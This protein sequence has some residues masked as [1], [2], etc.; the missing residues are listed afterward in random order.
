MKFAV[1]REVL[2]QPLQ[3][4]MGVVEKRQTMAVLNN[5]LFE[6]TS[7][8]LTLTG[9]DSEV[10][11]RSKVPLNLA[12]P[13]ELTVPARKLFD[14]VRSLG[15]GTEL[16]FSKQA[17]RLVMKAGRS[18]FTLATLAAVEFPSTD[19]GEVIFTLSIAQKALKEVLERVAFAMAVSDVRYYLNGMLFEVRGSGLRCVATDGHRLAIADTQS[20]LGGLSVERQIILP[21]KGVLELQKLLEGVDEPVSLAFSRNHVR[22]QVG[23]SQFTSKLIEGKFPDYEAVIPIGA[24]K[25][26]VVEREALRTALQRAAILANEK[27][28]GVRLE[29]VAKTLRVSAQNPEQEEAYEELNAET[30]VSGI[31]VGF[32]VN[33]LLDAISA[34]DGESLTLALRD[35][36]SSG[37]LTGGAGGRIRHVVM[38]LRL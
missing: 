31:S 34:L 35:S 29:L 12:E 9:S 32:N 28:R 4:V 17:E 1:L 14:L 19:V 27:Y 7:D 8:G 15:D 13:G 10:E 26:A 33:Y 24:E 25:K 37:L 5:L 21:R 11:L 38:P 22:A 2:M 36:N 20:E 6:V 23:A 3:K 18:R 16:Q 30:D